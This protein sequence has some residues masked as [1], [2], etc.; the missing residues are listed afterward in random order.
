[1]PSG[2][3][4]S[5]KKQNLFKSLWRSLRSSCFH[6]LFAKG[7]NQQSSAKR[8]RFDW[9]SVDMALLNSRNKTGPK[10]DPW[11]TPKRTSL[12]DDWYQF[13]L[14]DTTWDVCERMALIRFDVLLTVASMQYLTP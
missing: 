11:D 8:S 10:V 5:K 9:E 6:F 12:G 3:P 2:R 13:P 7:E 4:S 1:M 14:T